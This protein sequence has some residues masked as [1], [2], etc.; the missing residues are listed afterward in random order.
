MKRITMYKQDDSDY[1]FIRVY[2]VK[3]E[4]AWRVEGIYNHNQKRSDFVT[5]FSNEASAE[6]FFY[7]VVGRHFDTGWR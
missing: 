7:E 6:A 5:M 2:L 4:T 1:Q 3:I